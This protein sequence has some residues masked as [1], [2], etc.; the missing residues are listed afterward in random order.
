[1]LRNKSSSSL[2]SAISGKGKGSKTSSSSSSSLS[3]TAVT[4]TTTNSAVN[5]YTFLPDGPQLLSHHFMHE[6]V[7]LIDVH[8]V[9]PWILTADRSQN[10]IR[11]FDYEQKTEL[12]GIYLETLLDRRKREIEQ[13]KVLDR[14]YRG[15][16]FPQWYTQLERRGTLADYCT[17][18]VDKIMKNLGEL[19][20]VRLFDEDIVLWRLAYEREHTR[21]MDDDDDGDDGRHRQHHQRRQQHQQQRDYENE[22]EY[23]HVA[24]AV[25]QTQSVADAKNMKAVIRRIGLSGAAAEES[26]GKSDGSLAAETTL[27]TTPTDLDPAKGTPVSYSSLMRKMKP[28]PYAIRKTPRFVVLHFANRVLMLRYDDTQHIHLFVDEVKHTQLD[29]KHIVSLEFIYTHP[30]VALGGSDGCIR[31]WNYADRSVLPTKINAHSKSVGKMLI[32]HRD[33]PLNALPSLLSCGSDG[34]LCSWNLDKGIAE[35]EVSKAHDTGS[36]VDISL[37]AERGIITTLGSDRSVVQWTTSGRKIRSFTPSTKIGSTRSIAR[38]HFAS[39]VPSWLAI[40]SNSTNLYFIASNLAEKSW[41]E[42]VTVMSLLEKQQ[43]QLEKLNAKELS[44]GVFFVAQAHPLRPNML[45]VGSS[46]GLFVIKL[47]VLCSADG[48]RMPPVA[49]GIIPAAEI[50]TVSPMAGGDGDI[51]TLPQPSMMLQHTI[52]NTNSLASPSASGNQ[53]AMYYTYGSSVFRRTVT[54]NSGLMKN[55]YTEGVEVMKLSRTGNVQLSLSP[56]G[57]YICV[58]W[59]STLDFE[60]FNTSTWKLIASGS[61]VYDLVWSLNED[62]FA[63]VKGNAASSSSKSISIFELKNNSVVA[64]HQDI[65]H[66]ATAIFGGYLLGISE[67][68]GTQGEGLYFFT[69]DGE[70]ITDQPLP[71][72]TAIKWDALTLK[73]VI[74]FQESYAVFSYM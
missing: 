10:H 17:D 1:M 13:L 8:P 46:F 9:R 48:N 57:H 21:D 4:T 31:L 6:R 26:G 62:R 51:G 25:V 49:V 52:G 38:V 50:T 37:D 40:T 63:I 66:G 36:I 55:T 59:E 61:R 3:T 16:E 30:L 69:W 15:I 47:D 53:R 71:Q 60:V 20:S 54:S 34:S 7:H 33:D 39:C 64:I 67:S 5:D 11:L 42:S 65:H 24:P 12:L 72:P 23:S 73:C 19:R 45:F 18:S 58:Y 41:N 74:T 29:N 2:R 56:S 35:F 44:K 70:R 28:I 68:A 43:A 27:A 14:N 32:I 22:Y